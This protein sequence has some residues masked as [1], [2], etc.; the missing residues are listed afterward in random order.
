MGPLSGVVAQ[1]RAV[2]PSNRA[3]PRCVP[4]W[5]SGATTTEPA[6]HKRQRRRRGGARL[7]LRTL[8]SRDILRLHHS[9]QGE[10]M[11]KS[12]KQ[13]AKS[14]DSWW[15]CSACTGWE[16]SRRQSCRKC[17][18]ACPSWVLKN[19]HKPESAGESADWTAD[20]IDSEGI[21]TPAGRAQW[22]S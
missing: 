13:G 9:S 1:D 7:L 10:V 18:A 19:E 8:Q 17:G 20:D 16:W 15:A 14:K 21:R 4:E 22:I 2:E 5:G 12:N 3:A 6:W 11:G